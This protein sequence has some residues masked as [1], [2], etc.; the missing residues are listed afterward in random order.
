LEL[1]GAERVTNH[2]IIAIADKCGLLQTLKL[3]S[4]VRISDEAISHIATHS[5]RLKELSIL[6]CNVTSG[7]MRVIGEH[8]NVLEKLSFYVSPASQKAFSAEV[9]ALKRR[10]KRLRVQIC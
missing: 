4:C 6:S 3:T 7:V 10:R 8:C 2:A 1:R 9:A 5:V